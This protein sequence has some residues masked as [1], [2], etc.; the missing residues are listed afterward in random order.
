[1]DAID[2]EKRLATA[3]LTGNEE[4]IE[5]ELDIIGTDALEFTGRCYAAAITAGLVAT[6]VLFGARSFHLNVMD[7][8]AVHAEL[9]SGASGMRGLVGFLERYRYCRAQRTYYLPVVQASASVEPIRALLDAGVG[10]TDRDKSELLS[11]SVRQDNVALARTLV[12]GGARLYEDIRDAAPSDLHGMTS[13]A[14]TENPWIDQL[15]PRSSLAM[16]SFILEQ[17]A[18]NPC[19]I[20]ADWFKLYFRDP[21]F[22]DKLALIAP[23]GSWEL[24]EEPR[25]L[26]FE[27]ARGGHAKAVAAVLGWGRFEECDLD[28]AL[29]A[30]RDA[31]YIEIAAE[32]LRAKQTSATPLG[33]L[34]F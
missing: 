25:A 1:M 31:G 10:L 34:S 30:A 8:P 27:L 23:L 21:Q 28:A 24:C 22:G 26:L 3:V 4:L 29:D 16:I 17:V 32:I 20:R 14:Y 13:I 5:R 12:D 19:P 9:A 6:T 18:D 2:A 11:L 15:S 7:E 33:F